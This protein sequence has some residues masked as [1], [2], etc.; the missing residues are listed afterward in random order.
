MVE[1]CRLVAQAAHELAH[2]PRDNG[3]VSSASITALY[4]HALEAT[5]SATQVI[6]TADNGFVLIRCNLISADLM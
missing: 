1:V 4:H 2:E 3:S 6:V 5:R